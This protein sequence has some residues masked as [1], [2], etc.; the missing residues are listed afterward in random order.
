M[1]IMEPQISFM[2]G[3][4]HLTL[5]TL[6]DIDNQIARYEKWKREGEAKD[7]EFQSFH[8]APTDIAPVLIKDEN[9][10]LILQ[11]MVWSL[12]GWKPKPGDK[13]TWSTF[14]ARKDKLTSGNLWK[15]F[16]PA[17]RCIAPI[18]GFYE[19]TGQKGNKTP[20]YIFNKDGSHLLAAGIYSPYS[21]LEGVGSF[22]IITT[23]PNEFMSNIH[24]RMPAI[25]QPEE[26]HDWLNP[27][28][29]PDYLLDMLQ[30]Y[31]EEILG[32]YIVSKDVNSTRNKIN[33]PYLTQPATLL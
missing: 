13:K 22:T 19:F 20:H 5:R 18:S 31:P 28:H 6:T 27:D 12:S 25:L 16:F 24:D 4:Y 2:C 15:R 33:A 10:D 26:I 30:P 7:F 29:T 14:N 17:K 1:V 3:R 8:I 11:E 9:E 23:P 21:A 32:E